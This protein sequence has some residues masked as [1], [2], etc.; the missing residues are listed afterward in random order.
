MTALFNT[1]NKHSATRKTS[2][3]LPAKTPT[4]SWQVVSRLSHQH[5]RVLQHTAESKDS[6]AFYWSLL[7]SKCACTCL[8]L[9]ILL[10][11]SEWHNLLVLLFIFKSFSHSLAFG[12]HSWSRLEQLLSEQLTVIGVRDSKNTSPATRA[13]FCL[14]QPFLHCTSQDEVLS[15]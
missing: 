7:S 15:F 1:P 14:P 6:T 13:S 8:T 5:L 4:M 3:N 11:A 2:E 10:L 9:F 12:G